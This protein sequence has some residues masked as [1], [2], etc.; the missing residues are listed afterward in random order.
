MSSQYRPSNEA[1]V[2]TTATIPSTVAEGGH[3]YADICRRL[4]DLSLLAQAPADSGGSFEFTS[5]DRKSRY[6]AATDTYVD[7]DANWDIGGSLRPSERENGIV[8]AEMEGPGY[9]NR[10]WTTDDCTRNHVTIAIFIDGSSQPLLCMP[11]VDLFTAAN[12]LTEYE[13]LI[14]G[15]D[16]IFDSYIPITYRT[17]CRVELWDTKECFYH[18]GYTTLPAGST[19]ESFV[20]PLNDA[21][22][23]ALAEANERLGR[24]IVPDGMAAYSLP[25]GESI[26]LLDTTGAGAISGL[27][28]KLQA[29]SE[30]RIAVMRNLNL[31][32]Y[33]D[34]SEAA[35]VDVSVGDFFNTPTGALTSGGYP[36]GVTADGLLYAEWYM[37]FASG[38]K[39]QLVNH[40][41]ETV[42]IEFGVR[43]S[44][45]SDEEAAGQLRFLCTWNQPSSVGMIALDR[46]YGTLR[47]VGRLVGVGMH[48]Y[49]FDDNMWWGEGD[50]KFYIDGEKFPSWFG[51]GSE[52]YFGFSYASAVLF[53]K[54]YHTQSVVGALDDA[55]V[56]ADRCAMSLMSGNKVLSRYHISD[57]V[58]FRES[59]KVTFEAYTENACAQ[60]ACLYYY[61]RP[62]D[63]A[64][65]SGAAYAVATRNDRYR[66][67]ELAPDAEAKG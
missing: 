1:K 42:V 62:E 11:F 16:K 18:I 40:G 32:V 57:S 19:V 13:N 46:L 58:V 43:L 44:A 9:I 8:V 27:Y 17:S 22:K 4:H 20:Y 60:S 50:E 51:T 47:G 10:I 23:V 2:K 7:W 54:P 59:L 49:C 15:H 35:A 63:V 55:R 30:E 28:M 33:W 12:G 24:R 26:T 14:Y 56:A 66:L 67:C 34:A 39:L 61:V 64:A 52:D 45:L 53:N 31:K 3:T 29:F 38:A 5:Y 48:N 21:E 37:P 6:D 65:N 41:S 36:L 25:G